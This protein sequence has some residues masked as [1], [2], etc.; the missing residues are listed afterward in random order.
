MIELVEMERKVIVAIWLCFLA[1]GSFFAVL[2]PMWEGYDEFAHFGYVQAVALE[3]RAPREL[4]REIEASLRLVPL[5]WSLSAEP[6]PGVTHDAY[7]KLPEAERSR[8][9]EAVR[10]LAGPRPGEAEWSGARRNWEVQQPPLYYWLL[11]PV[12][13]ISADWGLAE[14]VWLLRMASVLLASLA[15]P[16]GFFFARELFG[17]GRLALCGLAVFVA[18]PGPV[19]SLVRV[20]NEALAIVMATALLVAVIG[21][22]KRPESIWA[23]AWLGVVM[24]AGLLTKAYFLTLLL[25]VFLGVVGRRRFGWFTAMA[26]V[27]PLLIAGAYYWANVAA[28]G[29]LT[30]EQ[31]EVAV[32]SL[33]W[34]ERLRLVAEVDWW[35]A[36]DSAFTSHIWFGNWSFLQLRSW[37]YRVWAL[38]YLA[39]GVGFVRR[40]GGWLPWQMV[41]FYICFL[42]GLAYHVV[43][44]Y[45]VHHLSTTTGWYINCLSVAEAALLGYGLLG[46]GL[47]ARLVFISLL[48]GFGAF[49]FFGTHFYLMPYYAGFTDHRAT[50]FVAAL[51]MGMLGEGGWRV[52]LNRLLV[53]R[54]AFFSFGGMALLWAVYVISLVVPALLPLL[55]LSGRKKNTQSA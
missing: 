50:S 44:I 25:A 19:M 29:A 22:V 23:H 21:V 9:E 36:I 24:G 27:I 2:L 6:P 3:G 49:E 46:L 13:W 47:S 43:I 37:M 34:S 52:L 38:V 10:Q 55:V 16:L 14:R 31:T 39:A 41:A 18:M 35:S 48:V 5:P 40:L 53:N 30:G 42:A 32:Q 12:Y 15:I 51:D 33:A 7:W 28:S 1:K 45:A 54:P 4:S 26:G 8:R 11:A 20:S 17:D